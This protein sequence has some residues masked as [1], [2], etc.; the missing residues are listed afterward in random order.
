MNLE[1]PLNYL[2]MLT[3]ACPFP[4]KYVINK[5]VT[6]ENITLKNELTGPCK[7]FYRIKN[8][9]YDDNKYSMA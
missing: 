2:F 3:V 4:V 7:M 9:G 8:T 6:F 1:N 5:I